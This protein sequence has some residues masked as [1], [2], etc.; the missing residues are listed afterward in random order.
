MFSQF[1]QAYTYNYGPS[2]TASSGPSAGAWIAYLVV[3]V[4]AVVALWRVFEKAGRPGWASII[5]VYNV[6]NLVKIAGRP[7]WWTILFFLPFINIIISIVVGIEVGKHFGHGTAFG[8]ILLGL[9]GI[10]YFIVGFGSDKYS[11]TLPAASATPTR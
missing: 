5:P 3:Y 4:L 6:Y 2:G 11:P 10:G 7:G 9:L 1:A 8:V